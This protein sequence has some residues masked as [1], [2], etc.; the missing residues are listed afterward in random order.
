M[1]KKVYVSLIADL[2]HAGHIKVLKEAEKHG[3]IVLGLLTSAA[4]NELN[5]TA[6]LKYQQR[7]DVLK[8][9]SMVAEVIEKNTAIYKGNLMKM[10]PDFVFHGDD[11]KSGRWE[12]Y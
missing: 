5:D 6:Y 3:E 2:L 9:L 11:W 7:L 1:N 10:K 4:I 12:Y 8:N